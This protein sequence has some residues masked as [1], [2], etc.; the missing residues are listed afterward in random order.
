MAA[1]R[2]QIETPYKTED[3]TKESALA[4]LRRFREQYPDIAPELS[5]MHLMRN[6]ESWD[7]HRAVIAAL[8]EVLAE[9]S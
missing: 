3:I 4:H 7:E 8:D 1:K 2:K 5:A 6:V 9:D